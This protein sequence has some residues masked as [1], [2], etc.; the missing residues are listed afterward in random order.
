MKSVDGA[1]Q[2]G[3]GDASVDDQALDLVEY[4]RVGGVGGVLLEHPPRHHRVEGRLAA[5]A[6]GPDLRP[7]R[8]WVRSGVDPGAPKS[9]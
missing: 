1:G 5:G 3:E 6:R 9:T 4:R 2:V 8:V 7:A